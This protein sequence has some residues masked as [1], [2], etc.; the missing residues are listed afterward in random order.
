MNRRDFS[1]FVFYLIF[2]AFVFRSLLFNLNINL[3]DWFDYPYV[4]WVIFQNINHINTLDFVNFFNTNA[5]YPHTNTLF[6]SDL[7]LPQSILAYPITLFSNNPILVFNI[8]FLS[9]FLL[10]YISSYF[11][12]KLIFK[13]ENIAFLGSIV[14]VLS[15][16]FFIQLSH[17]QML[18]FWPYLFC[19]YFLLKFKYKSKQIFLYIAGIFLTIQFTASA[20]LAVFLVTTIILYFI[21]D[22]IYNNNF[23]INLI[24]LIQILFVFLISSGMFIKGYI[25]TANIYNIKRDYGEY[26]QYSAHVTDYFFSN[27]INSIL[28]K[29]KLLT[30]WNSFNR[31]IDGELAVFPGFILTI[32]TMVS[33]LSIKKVKSRVTM[34]INLNYLDLFFLALGICGF[35]FSLGPRLSVNGEYVFFPLP[36]HFLTKIPFLGSVRAT[37]RWSY[38]LYTGLTY[39]FLKFLKR[40]NSGVVFRIIFLFIIIE[41]LPLNIV[42]QKQS[43][44]DSTDNILTN[45]CSIEKVPVLEIP[46][47]HLSVKGGVTRGL[48]YVTKNQLATLSNN[49]ILVNGYSGYDMPELQTLESEIYESIKQKNVDKLTKI[50]I[51]TNARIVVVNRELLDDEILTGYIG[52]YPMLPGNNIKMIE[53]DIFLIE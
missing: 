12:W 13:K 42:T 23:K 48:S 32:S 24:S 40:V 21:V 28:H 17:F 53:E 37:A 39:F 15:P 1:F 8:L 2:L 49:C 14:T 31:H 46:V 4:V 38:L 22:S 11:L 29:S 19:L 7:L 9:V 33:L 18:N 20:Y 25:D 5:F 43:Y 51:D 47:T 10:N 41:L 36:Y 52:I 6:F 27:G 35:I 34:R 26:V 3:V 50:L 45:T 16:F 44:L 30:L